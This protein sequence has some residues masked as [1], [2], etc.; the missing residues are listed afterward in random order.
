[1]LA[2]DQSLE[3]EKR[4][5]SFIDAL[6]REHGASSRTFKNAVVFCVAQTAEPL[7]EDARRALAW[8]EIQ[9]ELPTISVDKTQITQLE[10]NIKKSRR[11]LKQNV[12]RTYNQVALL[13]KNNEIRFIDLGNVTSSAASTLIQF[14]I[15]ELACG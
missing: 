2:P 13:G 8:E 3:D 7:S 10:D 9:K 4:T 15:H 1:M 11:D 5:R 14:I 12:W 6:I